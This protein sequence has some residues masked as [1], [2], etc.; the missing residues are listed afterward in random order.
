[1][2]L[3]QFN[4]AS[5]RRYVLKP[6][7]L[8]L[9]VLSIQG[10]P[11]W[12]FIVLVWM[13]GAMLIFL[14][15][16]SNYKLDKAF[17][18][19]YF[20]KLS[21][22]N[23]FEVAL[24]DLLLLLMTCL[25][26]LFQKAIYKGYIPQKVTSLIQR[27]Y[28]AAFVM[29]SNWYIYKADWN[30]T[31]SGALCL[32]SISLLCK[33]HSYNTINRRLYEQ[34]RLL[35]DIKASTKKT[36]LNESAQIEDIESVL[37]IEVPYNIEYSDHT[38]TPVL[39]TTEKL[40]VTYPDNV[41]FL[42]F[43]EYLVFPTL[44]YDIAYPRMKS[45]RWWFVIEKILEFIGSTFALYVI[46]ENYIIPYFQ[47]TNN[48]F[49]DLLVMTSGPFMICILL[50][51]NIIFEIICNV[52]AE[53]SFYADRNFYSDFWNSTNY[54]EFNRKWNKPVHNFL[55]RHVY[56]ETVHV[57]GLHKNVARI[58]TF[59]LSSVFHELVFIVVYKEFKWYMF[60]IQMLQIPL[61]ALQELPQ[62][63][64]YPIAGNIFFWFGLYCG[65]PLLCISYNKF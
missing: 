50:V 49:I 46:I 8:H 41:T 45:I 11:L 2:T 14:T 58:F 5:K 62:I 53:L 55:F 51:F 44:V 19:S 27:V 30:W 24:F 54:L 20:I 61:I 40:I 25:S 18:G 29:Y 23:I 56:L 13:S 6:T 33:I 47:N 52:C 1:M 32:H 21:L 15:L 26:F 60:I 7:P 22:S 4:N 3:R 9:R 34:K 48:S 43:F 10:N 42:N 28:E 16:Y 35:E 37:S 36:D 63:K 17:I 59:F 64:R 31:S 65:V 12:G 39:D 57:M 38:N